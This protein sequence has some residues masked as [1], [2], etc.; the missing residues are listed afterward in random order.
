MQSGVRAAARDGDVCVLSAAE[1][2]AVV[3]EHT[4]RTRVAG[5]S[6]FISATHTASPLPL[7]GAHFAVHT[8][9]WR[10]FH[11]QVSCDYCALDAAAHHEERAFRR[12]QLRG[13]FLYVDLA[14]PGTALR[15]ERPFLLWG[16]LMCA[17][18]PSSPFLTDPTNVNA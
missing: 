18:R 1:K 6:A 16:G 9:I 7:S 5:R 17:S 14:F 11:A 4:H 8:C 13:P 10:A 12:F 3:R 2:G 15:Y